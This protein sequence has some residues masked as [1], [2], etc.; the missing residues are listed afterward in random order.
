MLRIGLV[1]V[2]VLHGRHPGLLAPDRDSVRLGVLV[3]HGEGELGVGLAAG[4]GALAE[5]ALLDV[6]VS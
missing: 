3:L 6:E 5:A 2:A 1:L 4:I